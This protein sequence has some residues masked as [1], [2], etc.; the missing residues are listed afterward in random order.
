VEIEFEYSNQKFVDELVVACGQKWG[1]ADAN[2]R[3]VYMTI[4]RANYGELSS[5]TIEFEGSPPK[6]PVFVCGISA[7]RCDFA[8]V[9]LHAIKSEEKRRKVMQAVRKILDER[10]GIYGVIH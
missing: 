3:R 5:V 7:D 8:M 10:V 4:S 9:N 1:V 6:F 2:R